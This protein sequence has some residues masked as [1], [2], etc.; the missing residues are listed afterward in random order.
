MNGKR[1]TV[2]WSAVILLLIWFGFNVD[3]IM[4]D[5]DAIIRLVLGALFSLVI[6]LR[7]KQDAVA[8]SHIP[9]AIVAA[10]AL[11]GLIMSLGGAIFDVH[12]FKWLG[13]VL[14]I[15]AC[16]QWALPPRY[17]RDI[18]LSC[19]IFYWVHPLPAQVF[20]PLQL[21]MQRMSVMGSERL[22]H[23]LN[24]RVWADEMV[25][26][27]GFH[28]FGVPESCSGMRTAVTVLLCG[29]GASLLLRFRWYELVVLTAAGLAQVLFVNILRISFMVMMAP[30]KNA[31]WA[32]TFLHDTLGILLLITII[33][34]Q[35][36]AVIWSIFRETR[37]N[38]TRSVAGQGIAP[39]ASRSKLR[40]MFRWVAVLLPVLV[41]AGA[42][43][44][45]IYRN[46]PYHRA[47]MISIVS[48]RLVRSG[49]ENYE[50]A[51]K[52]AVAAMNL[53]PDNTELRTQ[54]IQVLLLRK[55]F[56]NALTE[57][58]KIHENEHPAFYSVLK[59]RA[60]MGMGRPDDAIAVVNALPDSAQRMPA[61][62]M[63]KAEF[64]AISDNTN[65]VVENIVLAA[66]WSAT[67]EKVRALFPYLAARQQWKTIAECKSDI[68]HGSL[69]N[70]LLEV[71][72]RLKLDDLAGGQRILDEAMEKWPDDAT[73]LGYVAAMAKVRTD[74]EWKAV[75]SD[76][77]IMD[78]LALAANLHSMID[79]VRALFPYL[80]ARQQWNTIAKCHSE[81][82]HEN[83]TNALIEVHADLKVNDI[84]S[85]G[86]V[87]KN[88]LKKWPENTRV[89]GYLAS[90]A[91]SRPGSEWE[92][93]FDDKLRADI[94]KLG[95]DELAAYIENSFL[96]YRPDLAWLAYNRLASLDPHDPALYLMP[97]QFGDM[98]F[99]FRKHQVGIAAALEDETVDLGSFYLKRLAWPAAPLA[100]ELTSSEA[101]NFRK[102]CLRK[103]LKQAR[104][105]EEQKKG[106]ISRE[107]A[108]QENRPAGEREKALEQQLKSNLNK[109]TADELDAYIEDSFALVRPDLAWAAYNRL[110]QLDPQHPALFL[111]PARFGEVWFM[112]RKHQVGIET[113]AADEIIYLGSLY[114]KIQN[115]PVAPLARQLTEGG[116]E[117]KR[118]EYLQ[119]C[120]DELE[121]REKRGK[122]PFQMGIM[123]T[124]ALKLAGKYDEAHS[125]LDELEKVYPSEKE[126]MLFRHALIYE[127]QGNWEKVYENLRQYSSLAEQPRL[128]V[129][130]MQINALMHLNMGVYALAVAENCLDTFPG[131]A[132]VYESLA[133]IWSVFDYPD[134]ALFFLDKARKG[135]KSAFAAQ[136]LYQTERF[137]E[138]ETCRQ[139]LGLRPQLRPP[140]QALLLPRAE[141]ALEGQWGKP[142]SNE[143]MNREAA[144]SAATARNSQSPFVRHLAS[145][146]A[147]WYEKRGAG[148]A[149]NPDRWIA[150]GRDDL[151]Q[152]VALS[153]LAVLLATQGKPKEAGV[154]VGQALEFLPDSAM[155]WR[156][157][158]ALTEGER[159]TVEEARK[160]CASDPEIWLAHLVLRFANEK[161]GNWALE[162]I[163]DA[164]SHDKFSVATI[165][166]AGDLMKRNGC[167]EA[168]AKAAR[169]AMGKGRGLL[170]AYV[171]ALRCA[172]TQGDITW[173]LSCAMNAAE[174]AVD[175]W[176]FYK[177]FAELTTAQLKT[178][179]VTVST[180]E[181]LC[182]KYPD[183]S[184]WA[185]KLGDVYL[186]SGNPKNAMNTLD[187]IL[188]TEFSNVD[189][190][191]LLMAA[192]ASQ[193][194]GELERAVSILQKARAAYPSS[195]IVLN[196]LVYTL[197]LDPRT[198]PAAQKLLPELLKMWGQDSPVV[199]DT[200]A[201]VCRQA[202]EPDKAKEYLKKALSLVDKMD[203]WWLEVNPF[204]M[205]VGPYLGKYDDKLDVGLGDSDRE[206][207]KKSRESLVPLAQDMARKVEEKTRAVRHSLGY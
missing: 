115:W 74:R 118:R 46:R 42:V 53:L 156:M 180:L 184:R 195:R 146:K 192:E 59:S 32:T 57:L 99:T 43:A 113:A 86:D 67:I 34:V 97:A 79:R 16:L 141:S 153:K 108:K 168:A 8:P 185:S 33:A 145:L 201:F 45:A 25:L 6:L 191:I 123:H 77:K 199:F 102:E 147:R 128:P 121:R 82:P 114:Q 61:I 1:H 100:R 131:S 88:A 4:T 203:P 83:L 112:F 148:D 84:I 125:K 188:E 129:N 81:L 171:L 136:L 101:S 143:E 157:R 176:P 85:A 190:R 24:V 179:A 64:A 149:S 10:L 103:G 172:L 89:L 119:L 140:K 111:A 76:K 39:V 44:A 60:L 182:A 164:V 173:A 205:N 23:A 207:L 5:K 178:D 169:Y 154:V 139:I 47:T 66:N 127:K 122:L 15:C 92:R 54:W 95:P 189:L 193:Q 17:S 144:G 80:A 96:M 155:L 90:M 30:G 104:Q 2:F 163:C 27:T 162:E 130:L 36:E 198:V 106:G 55:K 38:R 202:N 58:E 161:A 68:P 11:V 181:K 135:T 206:E 107:A 20:A 142:L 116:V 175:P 126:E 174:N 41:V 177:V 72:A 14:L 152:G 105:R 50:N 63:V 40:L 9:T 197:A 117:G 75:F 151:E 21:F 62:A 26:C 120:L 37:R 200:A 159:K 35:V 150:A 78:N 91:R 73:L 160:R 13:F 31:D 94:T 65:A 7:R 137:T 165:V 69:S 187:S 93:L 48:D 167:L 183:D 56:E 29:L 18:F 110:K 186:R 132:Q 166:R 98:W 3:P 109:L 138:A 158:I 204:A 124:T 87:I 49:P 71:H 22:L 28:T 52:A 134:K 12:Q 133:A 194:A 70:A 51:E 170:P 19:F 196:N